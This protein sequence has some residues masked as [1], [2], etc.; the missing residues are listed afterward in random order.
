MTVHVVTSA[1]S[2]ARDR[3]AIDSGIPSRALMQRAGAAAAAEIAR[4]FGDRLSRGVAV[5]AGKGNNGGDAWV[6]AGALAAVGVS[7]RVA[8]AGEPKTDD[9]RA[10]RALALG[11]L[12]DGT[13]TGGE[14]LVI[15]GVLGTGSG[16]TAR[17]AA[18][19]AIRRINELRTNGAIVVALDVPSGVDASTGEGDLAV[20]ADLTISFGT[21]KRGALVRRELCGRIVVVDIGF[22]EHANMDDGAPTLV[23]RAWVRARIPD[24]AAN[25]HKGTRR[26][27]AIVGG[28]AGMA[29]AVILAARAA[30]RSGVGMAR[31]VV[32]APSIG[33]VQ[34]S[35]PAALTRPW[36]ESDEQI[37]DIVCDW[38]HAVV[39]GP[40]L[41]RLATTRAQIE[42]LLELWTGPVVIDADA[43][44]AFEGDA[45]VLGELLAGRRAIVTPHVVEFSRLSG[46]SADDV[47]RAPYDVGRDLAATLG[48]AVLLKGV[49]TV[50]TDA[51]GRSL[52]SASGTPALATGGSGDV[53]AGIAGTLLAQMDD[54]LDAAAC[55][56]WIHGRAGEIA[57]S[58]GARGATVDDVV[59]ALTVV[60]SESAPAP[61]PPVLADLPAIDPVRALA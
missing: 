45:R 7:V 21:V 32:Q 37:R 16:G 54:P 34:G 48:C 56:A 60:W 41:G 10:E 30:L 26:R 18:A 5:F 55:A 39:I 17:G 23:D 46:I 35:V 1:Q 52:V 11:I 6:I 13:Q 53:L 12:K 44:T 38:A 61:R 2:A 47:A 19:D 50:I 59:D 42:K 27:V 31:A 15:D 58:R 29:G 40:G 57:G 51:T 4:A 36:P 22:G 43:L 3:H 8:Q 33:A 25:A 24:I 20:T 28:V 14:E 49:P 9:A